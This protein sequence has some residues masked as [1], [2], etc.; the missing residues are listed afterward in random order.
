MPLAE[1]PE[2]AAPL[3]LSLGRRLT[4]VV[5]TFTA[6]GEGAMWRAAPAE[7]SRIQE[8]LRLAGDIS[9]DDA[10]AFSAPEYLTPLGGESAAKLFHQILLT[11]ADTH[12]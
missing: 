9:C 5:E 7:W 3:A 10:L 4:I 6:Q 2:W 12:H 1:W 8:Q 11:L